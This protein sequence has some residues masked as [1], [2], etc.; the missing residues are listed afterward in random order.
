MLTVNE[1]FEGR[2]KSIGF[3]DGNG[4]ATMG[5]MDAGE[6]RFSTNTVEV[7]SVITGQLT[8]KLPGKTEWEA[9]PAGTAFTVAKGEAFD[10][11]IA[12]PSAY[13]C[14]YS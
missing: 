12:Q 7:M 4:P 5:V 8:V 6:Y 13:L 10:V 3:E 2:V 1:Y 11:R 14:R 9:Y